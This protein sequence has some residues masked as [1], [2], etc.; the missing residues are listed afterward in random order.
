MIESM[1]WG[2][3]AFFLF[4]LLK[5]SSPFTFNDQNKKKNGPSLFWLS[6]SF[7]NLKGP[8][9]SPSMTLP[10]TNV[11]VALHYWT[12]VSLFEPLLFSSPYL[13]K[14]MNYDIFL[15]ICFL[16]YFIFPLQ[17]H[18]LL[19]VLQC[20]CWFDFNIACSICCA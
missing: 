17:L 6:H 5:M 13:Y 11:N 1:T 3:V 12:L 7:K 8:P 4:K 20:D 2:H 15:L 9:S 10:P 14:L 18:I 16:H 19:C